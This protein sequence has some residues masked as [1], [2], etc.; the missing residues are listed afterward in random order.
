[1]A[2]ID[3][4]REKIR[5]RDYYLSSHAE[6]EMADDG[7]ERKDVENALLRGTIE[8]KLT[9]DPRGTRYQVEGPAC[10]GRQMQVL[11]RFKEK[12]PLIIITVYEKRFQ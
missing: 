5:S 8:K 6:D 9:H 10:D 7:F 3:R 2:I 11:C 12:G 1:M 4:I